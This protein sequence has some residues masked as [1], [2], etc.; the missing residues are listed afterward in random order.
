MALTDSGDRHTSCSHGAVAAA[1]SF[2]GDTALRQGK[3]VY[4]PQVPAVPNRTQPGLLNE[5]GG[6]LC[7]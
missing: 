2:A 5:H 6:Q 3:S 1:G 4:Q 7:R